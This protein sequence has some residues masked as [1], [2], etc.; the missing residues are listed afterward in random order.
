MSDT[1]GVLE[2]P[3]LRA[4]L[5]LLADGEFHSGEELGALLGVSRA[6]VWKRL[7]KLELLGITLVSARGR[8]YCI[9]GGLDL[10]DVQSLTAG[11]T[12]DC[13]GLLREIVV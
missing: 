7:Q 11:I 6:A 2:S 12:C 9:E 1:A 8:G 13:P 5:Q 10:I 3:Q 4:L